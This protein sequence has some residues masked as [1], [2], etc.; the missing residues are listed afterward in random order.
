MLSRS[1]RRPDNPPSR[2]ISVS[3]KQSSRLQGRLGL[4]VG[5]VARKYNTILNDKSFISE[6]CWQSTEY[7]KD[8][9]KIRIDSDRWLPQSAWN[10]TLPSRSAKGRPVRPACG[11]NISE[12]CLMGNYARCRTPR[13]RNS[14]Q[15]F[16]MDQKA[17]LCAALVCSS[18]V[19]AR[20]DLA[21]S[22]SLRHEC[23]V[24]RD[25]NR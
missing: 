20:K 14:S 2:K 18:A 22:V 12:P 9:G 5:Q 19:R 6:T 11:S 8:S 13:Q 24:F 23:S 4:G 10:S 21:G 15:D 17:R 16:R 1:M 7:S 25:D 3:V